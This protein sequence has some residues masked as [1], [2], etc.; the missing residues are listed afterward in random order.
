ML[1]FRHSGVIRTLGCGASP[2][3]RYR[4][5]LRGRPVTD[6]TWTGKSLAPKT[7]TPDPLRCLSVTAARYSLRFQQNH[8]ESALGFF[9]TSLFCSYKESPEPFFFS[10]C[11]GLKSSS[12]ISWSL[13]WTGEETRTRVFLPPE[14]LNTIWIKVAFLC[15]ISL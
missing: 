6:W 2:P 3:S 10:V 8:Q 4:D 12:R 14:L 13:L 11:Q 9:L 1:F 7:P 15:W 5:S